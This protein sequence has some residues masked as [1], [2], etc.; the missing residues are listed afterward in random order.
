MQDG[1]VVLQRQQ[2][3]KQGETGC[4][5]S[6]QIHK[7]SCAVIMWIFDHLQ[8]FSQAQISDAANIWTVAIRYSI[9]GERLS[10][11]FSQHESA[12]M[13]GTWKIFADWITCKHTWFLYDM[14]LN[15]L[16]ECASTVNYCYLSLPFPACAESWV[17]G[18]AY[19]FTLKANLKLYQAYAQSVAEHNLMVHCLCRLCQRQCTFWELLA[20]RWIACQ[21]SSLFGLAS[22]RFVARSVEVLCV[23][24]SF[25]G[26]IT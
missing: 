24:Q 18:T 13:V 6:R 17:T 9:Q 5:F 25:S 22:S 23:C 4:E 3:C 7:S 26:E 15:D 1:M 21:P 16:L 11:I 12:M 19:N 14:S 10:S 2:R 8:W 20:W